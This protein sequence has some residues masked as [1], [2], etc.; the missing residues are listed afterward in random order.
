MTDLERKFL[1][2]YYLACDTCFIADW[3]DAA[4]AAKDMYNERRS[5]SDE[6]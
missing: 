6:V 5:K 3:A 4:E 2:L 1:E